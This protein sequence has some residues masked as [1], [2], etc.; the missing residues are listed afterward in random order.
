MEAEVEELQAQKDK[1]SA[2]IPQPVNA[3]LAHGLS[4]SFRD[5]LHRLGEQ[6]DAISDATPCD[7]IR[8]SLSTLLRLS[9]EDVDVGRD[10]DFRDCS[11]YDVRVDDE[12]FKRFTEAAQSLDG[13]SDG[14]DKFIALQDCFHHPS[15]PHR[16]QLRCQVVQE[17]R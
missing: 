6:I 2:L 3:P 10:D 5:T 1:V 14:P 4:V 13:G 15:E 7:L 9:S 11:Q 12:D 17:L 8:H 16:Q